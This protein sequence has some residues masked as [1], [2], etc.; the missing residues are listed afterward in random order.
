MM[1]ANELMATDGDGNLCWQAA[2]EQEIASLAVG[3]R[4]FPKEGLNA[5]KFLR[6]A[7]IA[8]LTRLGG[9]VRQCFVVVHVTCFFLFYFSAE[10]LTVSFD[11]ASKSLACSLPP[12][13]PSVSFPLSTLRRV[14]KPSLVEQTIAV[15]RL[16][17]AT[18]QRLKMSWTDSAA[19]CSDQNS[20]AMGTEKSTLPAPLFRRSAH[21]QATTLL[22]KNA[23]FAELRTQHKPVS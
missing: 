10:V 1:Y 16:S 2:F 23:L 20:S 3:I 19:A 14:G 8:Q 9:Q 17:A 15:P 18:C 21:T 11:V 4:S 6:D 5:E 7:Y 12:P 22:G 13:S